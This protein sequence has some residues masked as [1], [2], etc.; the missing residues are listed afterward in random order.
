MRSKITHKIISLSL[1][2]LLFN[3]TAA[4]AAGDYNACV[5]KCWADNKPNGD[6]SFAAINCVRTIC[7]P[8]STVTP[9]P[10]NTDSPGDQKFILNVQIGNLK[11]FT[12]NP[13]GQGNTNILG[14]YIKAW[15]GFLL[16]TIG[17]MATVM[18]MWGGFKYLISR[19]DSGSITQAKSVIISA[20]SGVVIAFGTYT[21]LSLVNPQLMTINMPNL[22]TI[23]GG[24]NV[25][26]AQQADPH[27]AT[28]IAPNASTH[29]LASNPNG[30]G[31][32]SS[33]NNPHSQNLADN[34]THDLGLQTWDI[35]PAATNS[36][37]LACVW[38]VGQIVNST[39]GAQIIQP[40]TLGVDGERTDL[41]N[42]GQFQII[43]NADLGQSSP[44]D[45]IIS[46]GYNGTGHTGIVGDGGQ[47]ISNQ[48][49]TGNT[50]VGNYYSTDSH[51]GSYWGNTFGGSNFTT[52]YRPKN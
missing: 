48:G 21:L 33:G 12:I 41:A 20:I 28:D 4:L 42:S 11:D 24:G 37:N 18:I 7:D 44:G 26:L 38:V 22:T 50:R 17:I 5:T 2:F 40:G 27:G 23:Q 6:D 8:M 52:I 31:T 34:A 49:T 19:G 29:P 45:I 51:S 10:T 13:N 35:A 1:L 9:P 36:G 30:W 16:G 15:Y 3:A 39:Y 14:Q 25:K 32:P 46:S 43:N 47:I